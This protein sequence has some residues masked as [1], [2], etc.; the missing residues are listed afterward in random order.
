VRELALH[1]KGGEKGLS[2]ALDKPAISLILEKL[3][4]PWGK[5][6]RERMQNSNNLPLI[7]KRRKKEDQELMKGRGTPG[8]WLTA[9]VE[10]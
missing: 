4:K 5:M 2:D 3:R 9:R 6:K 7:K 8:G 1:R 10:I